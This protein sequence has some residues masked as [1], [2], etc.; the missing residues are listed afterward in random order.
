MP[1]PKIESCDV[2]RRSPP[3]MEILRKQRI[4]D[5]IKRKEHNRARYQRRHKARAL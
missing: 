3:L 2:I 4:A 5:A 1:D